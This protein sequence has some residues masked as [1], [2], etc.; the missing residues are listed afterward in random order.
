MKLKDIMVT[1]V[2]SIESEATV[3]EAANKMALDEIGS[4][5]VTEKGTPAGIVT[6]RDLLSRVLATGKNAEATLV[7][8]I[9]SK[10]LICG[11]PEMDVTEAARFMCNRGIK[12]LPVTKKGHLVGIVTLTDLAAVQPDLTKIIEEETKG[13]LPKRFIKRL[14]KKFYHT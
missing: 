10:P 11:D 14:S 5:V 13:K 4:L 7:R 2:V 1:D 3:K 6:E 8:R 9:M 12:K